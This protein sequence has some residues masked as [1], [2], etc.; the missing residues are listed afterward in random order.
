MAWGKIIGRFA[1]KADKVALTAGENLA[2]KAAK[3]G[4]SEQK[5]LELQE[6]GKDTLQRTISPEKLTK[7]HNQGIHGY[8]SRTVVNPDGSMTKVLSNGDKVVISKNAEGQTVRQVFRNGNLMVD[9]LKTLSHYKVGDKTVN[10]KEFNRQINKMYYVGEGSERSFVI[11]RDEAYAFNYKAERVMNADGKLL[12]MRETEFFPAHYGPS[13]E[14]IP[15]MSY[16]TKTADINGKTH[17]YVKKFVQYNENLAETYGKP[18]VNRYI[19][20]C[21]NFAVHHAKKTDGNV[22]RVVEKSDFFISGYYGR[23]EP[24]GIT[25]GLG[26]YKPVLNSGVAPRRRGSGYPVFTGDK[27]DQD[28]LW[29]DVEY[30]KKGLPLPTNDVPSDNMSLRDMRL[31]V[32]QNHSRKYYDPEHPIAYTG[33]GVW[34]IKDYGLKALDK[35]LP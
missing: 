30:N 9:D 26:A 3:Y 11:P 19:R 13:G 10:V 2:A 7:L 28:K 32:S 18:T 25:N 14:Y 6:L 1:P 34:R 17:G 8:Y 31:F 16:I 15:E 21:R 5:L 23:V 22:K 29:K 20:D 33:Y 12:G 35:P 4:I 27:I 24:K